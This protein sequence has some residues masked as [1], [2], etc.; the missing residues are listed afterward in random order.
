M[1]GIGSAVD[2]LR[3]FGNFLVTLFPELGR[4]A[5]WVRERFRRTKRLAP[6]LERVRSGRRVQAVIGTLRTAYWPDY[7]RDRLDWAQLPQE[8]VSMLRPI[9]FAALALFI[10]LPF[11]VGRPGGAGIAWEG[12]S[13]PVAVWDMV[14]W[15]IALAVAWGCLLI[16]AASAN[17]VAYPLALALF[18]YFHTYPALF[19]LPRSWWNLS[20]PAATLAAAYYAERRLRR[21]PGSWKTRFAAGASCLASGI[22]VSFPLFALTPLFRLGVIARVVGGLLIGGALWWHFRRVEP[23]RVET[24]SVRRTGRMPRWAL[25]V[26]GLVFLFWFTLVLR[27]GWKI[28]GQGVRSFFELWTGYL[29]P[30]WYLL[31]AGFIWFL[32]RRARALIQGLQEMVSA[33]LIVPVVLVFV[34]AGILITW[35]DW[36]LSV[37]TVRWPLPVWKAAEALCHFSSSW[38]WGHDLTAITAGWL[39]WVFAV[40]VLLLLHFAMVRRLSSRTAATVLFFTLL[41]GFSIYEYHRREFALAQSARPSVFVLLLFA[42]SILW[43]LYAAGVRR[44]L[45]GS[46]AWPVPAR[47]AIFG[48]LFLFILLDIHVRGA[49][50]D[51][52]ATQLITWYLFRG[53]VDVGLPYFLFVYAASRTSPKAALPVPR[54]VGAFAVGGL[55]ALLLNSLD[56]FVAAGGSLT[57]LSDTLGRRFGEVLAG[58]RYVLI[59]DVPEASLVWLIGRTAVAFVFLA[60]WAL[61]VRLAPSRRRF[62][63]R[64]A[65]LVA[66]GFLMARLLSVWA[67]KESWLGST[68]SVHTLTIIGGIIF[69]LVATSLRRTLVPPEPLSLC[70]KHG[71]DKSNPVSGTLGLIGAAAGL[72]A[73][74]QIQ[75]DVPFISPKWALLYAPAR[76]SL[77]IDYNLVWLWLGY[78]IPA[79]ILA[80]G[81]VLSRRR[82][83]LRCAGLL[84]GGLWMAGVL[85]LWARNEFW[86]RATGLVHTLT[87][88]GGIVFVLLVVG[89]R[90][91]LVP[92]EPEATEGDE[93]RSAGERATTRARLWTIVSLTMVLATLSSVAGWQAV[94]GRLVSHTLPGATAPLWLP[95]PWVRESS[96]PPVVWAL[97]SRRTFHCRRVLLFIGKREAGQESAK[98]LTEKF[99]REGALVFPGFTPVGSLKPLDEVYPGGFIAD[100]GFS[101]P[102]GGGLSGPAAG[103]M[104]VLPAARGQTMVLTLI[105]SLSDREQRRWELFMI[106]K[107]LRKTPIAR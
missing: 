98:E 59:R 106:A 105:T 17:R 50:G 61:A 26:G 13:K 40:D 10:L 64:R 103:A 101:R 97:F 84:A 56:R 91:I 71:A 4:A 37:E 68:T 107:A 69:L 70:R 49:V 30:L 60:G 43:L 16:G 12:V 102:L 42:L 24:V 72:A 18:V 67:R 9:F 83:L 86:L 52:R 2:S 65:G 66:G 81:V 22:M 45:R 77:D 80:V 3:R 55:V 41:L 11:A 48:A 39:R 99:L 82:F 93:P 87:V 31:G 38:I 53:I 6:A 79:M 95:A 19:S 57:V 1:I 90:R 35:S 76:S 34:L 88:I 25:T 89:L 58:D 94:H 15:L 47:S 100:F 14:V 74:S 23:A 54:L 8:A 78:V 28:A 32:L 27:G 46:A 36:I 5:H 92:V 85:L 21:A 29:W 33:W 63:L 104:A 7:S 51:P 73:F 75:L 62:L 44:S 20:I 96:A